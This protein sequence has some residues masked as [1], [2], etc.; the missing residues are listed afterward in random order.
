[1]T[2][3]GSP[4]WNVS[5]RQRRSDLFPPVLKGISSVIGSEGLALLLL[6]EQNNELYTEA[7]DGKLLKYRAKVGSGIAG[8]AVQLGQALSLLSEDVPLVDTSHYKT[9]QNREH[10]PI[11]S[12]MCVPIIN[13][14]KKCIGAIECINKQDSLAGFDAQD[15]HY[16]TQVAS[17][18]SMMV[19]G[20][21]SGLR[22]VLMMTHQT[23]QSKLATSEA[24]RDRV[25]GVCF[26]EQ[27]HNLYPLPGFGDV[28]PFVTISIVRGDPLVGQPDYEDF[29]MYTMKKR[30]KDQT[31]PVRTFAKSEIQFQQRNPEW[32]ESLAVI[33]PQKLAHVPIKELWAHVLVW[34]YDAV[35]Q[36][37][38]IGQLAVP[39]SDLPLEAGKATEPH[40][41][42]P[43]PGQPDDD[44]I[45]NTQ[46]WLSM[47]RTRTATEQAALEGELGARTNTIS[48]TR[49]RLG[50]AV[51]SSSPPETL[52]RS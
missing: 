7:V 27:A 12:A 37:K 15:E 11:H 32:H 1:M 23:M 6:D 14:A 34:H 39:M 25:A 4:Q 17:H 21:D 49:S 38:L 51:S 46:I 19:E 45:E 41:L 44:R 47:C 30:L 20:P 52:L 8:R 13:T 31:R 28:S 9:G 48:R 35:G 10:L 50:E 18:I 5:A 22:K 42:L 29:Q 26:L 2:Q 24:P 33:Y 16:V 36:D 43:F 3:Q 40:E